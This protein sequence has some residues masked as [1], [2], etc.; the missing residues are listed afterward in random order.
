MLRERFAPQFEVI[1]VIF[2]EGSPC[3]GGPHLDEERRG[4]AVGGGGC[5]LNGRVDDAMDRRLQEPSG[6]PLEHVSDVDDV[7]HG[8][9]PHAEPDV[10]AS[11]K[12]R[13]LS[14]VQDLRVQTHPS[15]R[16]S[17]CSCTLATLATTVG[18]PS[19]RREQER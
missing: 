18:W 1:R 12:R 9:R 7:P 4:V 13:R 14:T 2:L 6:P 3:C 17:N 15:A 16:F 19:E 8:H 10:P 11:P 5:T